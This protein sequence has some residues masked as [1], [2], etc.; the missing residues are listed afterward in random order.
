VDHHQLFLEPE[1]WD[2]NEFYINGLSMSLPEEIQTRVLRTIPGLKPDVVPLRPGY[3]VEYDFV[4]PTGLRPTLEARG[5]GGLFLAGQINGTT[6]YEEAAAQGLVAG[7]NAVRSLRGQ[8]GWV[9]ARDEAYIGVL[10]DDLVTKGA[11]EPYRMFTSRAEYR[12]HL[13]QDNADERLLRHARAIGLLGSEDLSRL[14]ERV[15]RVEELE[16]RLASKKRD[17]VTLAELLGRPGVSID[18]WLEEFPFLGEY[19]A[20]EREKVRVR[21]KYRGYLD[22]E[23]GRIRRFRGLEGRRIPSDLDIA[24]IRGIST[25]GRE[26][27]ARI[28]PE[29]VGQASRIPGVSPADIHVLLVALQRWSGRGAA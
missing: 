16:R 28:Q 17:G 7:V 23:R 15:E 3:A 22:R 9:L 12:L 19:S 14:E 6:G 20:E 2:T 25:E 29:T 21:I 18:G 5:V 11:D 4:D 10:I 26:K 27:L 13:R 24:S 1:G 8:E